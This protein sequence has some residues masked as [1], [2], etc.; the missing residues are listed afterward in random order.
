M[1]EITLIHETKQAVRKRL[2]WRVD[3]VHSSNQFHMEQL[4]GKVGGQFNLYAG[5]ITARD[6]RFSNAHVEFWIDAKN[7]YAENK[8]REEFLKSHKV[9]KAESYPH[10]E[11]RS[12]RIRKLG[13]IDYIMEG[14]LTI[15]GITKKVYFEIEC[16]APLH[17]HWGT[18]RVG[19]KVRGEI[20]RM[21]FGMKSIRPLESGGIYIDK[22]IKFDFDLVFVKA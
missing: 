14:D 21:D 3:H 13:M 1:Q 18:K 5:L 2:C 22:W 7:I 10:I 11:F 19:F 6:E 9:F 16:G 8:K 4:F 15:R 20:N 17:N 12:T